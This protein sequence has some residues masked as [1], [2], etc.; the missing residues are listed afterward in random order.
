M[1]ADKIYADP[2]TITGSIGNFGLWMSVPH[3]LEKIGVHSDGVGTTPLAGVFD[4]T[5]PLDPNA[6]TMIQSVIDQGYA[7]FIGKVAAARGSAPDKI[8]SV[9]RGRVWSGAQAKERGLIDV[10]G[11]LAQAQEEAAKLAKLGPK[12]YELEYVEAPLS[13]LEQLFLDMSKRAS[14]AGVVRTLG[15]GAALLRQ[16]ELER[17][18]G[19]LSWLQR[20]RSG[21]PVKAIAHCFCGL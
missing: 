14:T 6:S 18:Q 16:D 21:L 3:T 15:P 8:D 10:L 2:S 19:E 20:P 5:R 7:Q 1:N 9:A 13:G 17:V 12:D 4:P 11:G